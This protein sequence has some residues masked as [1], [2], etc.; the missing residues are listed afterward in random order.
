MTL[1]DMK[2]FVC[3]LCILHSVYK[4]WIMVDHLESFTSLSHESSSILT[5]AYLSTLV[6]VPTLYRLA[7]TLWISQMHCNGEWV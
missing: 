3:V 5:M 7:H 4:G 6:L 1:C 2:D